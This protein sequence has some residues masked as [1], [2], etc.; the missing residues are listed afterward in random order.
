MKILFVCLGNICRSPM[1]H[2]VMQHLVRKAGLSSQVQVDSCGMFGHPEDTST[3]YGTQK[4]IADNLGISFS[5][6]SRH[7]RKSDYDDFDLILAMDKSNFQDIMREVGR[8]DQSKVRMFRDYD[9]EGRGDVPDPY[10]CGRFELVYSM[11][12]RTC[13]S[14]LNHIESGKPL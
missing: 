12:E 10:Y 7:W 11:V 14:I 5:K 9:P 13:R 2:G 8:R 3:E 4:A 6:K 1:A